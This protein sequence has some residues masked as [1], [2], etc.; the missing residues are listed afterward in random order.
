MKLEKS[1]EQSKS[2][3]T[4]ILRRSLA[5]EFSKNIPHSFVHRIQQPQIVKQ[6]ILGSSCRHFNK[7]QLFVTRV[8][9]TLKN[10]THEAQ[11]NCFRS[12]ATKKK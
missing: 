8:C 9:Q 6:L 5:K 11:V 10:S 7:Q 12:S 2:F 4:P 1:R 3:P